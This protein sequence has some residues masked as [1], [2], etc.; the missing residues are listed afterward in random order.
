VV[1]FID[2]ARLYQIKASGGGLGIGK[3]RGDSGDDVESNS[4]VGGG[5]GKKSD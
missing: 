3:G 1:T 4:E 5:L 2:E